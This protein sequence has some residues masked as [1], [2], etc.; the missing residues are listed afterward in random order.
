MRINNNPRSGWFD[1][2]DKRI[3]LYGE[4]GVVAAETGV[5]RES[6]GLITKNQKIIF[7]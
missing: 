6:S 7:T 2:S 1:F 3:P 4:P 5:S